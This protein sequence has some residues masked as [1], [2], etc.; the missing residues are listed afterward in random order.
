L[1]NRDRD[2]ISWSKILISVFFFLLAGLC[3]IGGG[4][5]VWLWLR[6]DMSWVLGVFGG[7][8]LF[9][10]GIVPTFQPSHFHRIYSAYGGIFIVMALLWGWIFQGIRPD[11][12]DIIGSIISLIGVVIIFYMPRKNELISSERK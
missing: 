9:A 11:T 8:V 12:F 1:V 2:R 5:L 6:E 10:Y 3:E 7:F 4:Y